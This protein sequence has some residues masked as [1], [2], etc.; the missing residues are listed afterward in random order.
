VTIVFTSNLTI[1][2]QIFQQFLQTLIWDYLAFLY[3]C[4]IWNV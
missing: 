3:S 4:Q 1:L 2:N